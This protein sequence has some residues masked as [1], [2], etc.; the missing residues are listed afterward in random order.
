[1]HFEPERGPARADLREIGALTAIPDQNW[2][3]LVDLIEFSGRSP[4]Q[5][6]GSVGPDV[7]RM[8]VN[9]ALGDVDNTPAFHRRWGS[10]YGSRGLDAINN[11]SNE[12]NQSCHGEFAGPSPEQP[13]DQR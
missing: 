4:H 11:Q 12:Q 6:V 10:H 7:L 2:V 5:H 13:D 1:M 3:L 8:A 9:A